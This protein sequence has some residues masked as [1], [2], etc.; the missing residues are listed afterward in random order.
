MI[1]YFKELFN[2][3]KYLWTTLDDF[4]VIGL[5]F[6]VCVVLFLVY[7]GVILLIDLIKKRKFKKCAVK[8][9]FKNDICWHHQDCFKCRNYK[10]KGNKDA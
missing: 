10:K 2:K 7:V 3:P 8:R 6:A 4:A 5:V 1:N 9:N